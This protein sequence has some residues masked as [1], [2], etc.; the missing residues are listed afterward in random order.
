MLNHV[1]P[2]N[3]QKLYMP[4]E[5]D[6]PPQEKIDEPVKGE[7]K[8]VSNKLTKSSILEMEKESIIQALIDN[9]GVKTK[10]AAQLGMSTRQISYKI[11]KFDINF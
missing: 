4:A 3:Y 9:R 10:A 11:L 5:L 1:L 7:E 2:F 6:T 8:V